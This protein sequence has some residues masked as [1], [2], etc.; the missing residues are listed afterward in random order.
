MNGIEREESFRTPGLDGR[1]FK[2]SET[3]KTTTYLPTI[4]SAHIINP[5]EYLKPG[6]PIRFDLV[7]QVGE[8]GNVYLAVDI[9]RFERSTGQKLKPKQRDKM[10]RRKI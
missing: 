7:T 1:A 9:K 2:E 3:W 4:K 5:P 10:K 8:G 6:L